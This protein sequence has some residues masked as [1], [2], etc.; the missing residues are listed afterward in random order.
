MLPGIELTPP[1]LY[2]PTH[3][4]TLQFKTSEIKSNT[5]EKRKGQR[6]V[7]YLINFNP[8]NPAM[9]KD[10][11]TLQSKNLIYKHVYRLSGR[12]KL[13]SLLTVFQLVFP[14]ASKKM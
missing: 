4:Y 12:P 2:A 11:S 8:K 9:Y 6:H 10:V 3:S 13:E 1:A 7:I 5:K 14:P